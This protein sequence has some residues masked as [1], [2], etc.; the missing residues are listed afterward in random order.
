MKIPVR[1]VM[2]IVAVSLMVVGGCQKK[3]RED[4]PKTSF[5]KKTPYEWVSLVRK[6]HEYG[7]LGEYLKSI[8]TAQKALKLNPRSSEAFRLIGNAYELMADEQ[9]V[10]GNNSKAD[11]YRNLAAKY[12][13]EAKEIN[14][15]I[16]IP[17]Y[18]D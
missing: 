14:P 4:A 1:L 8:K 18:H 11:E 5:E 17:F 15:N 10:E 9:E 12:W 16:I 3:T 13:K 6:A 7:Q 2:T